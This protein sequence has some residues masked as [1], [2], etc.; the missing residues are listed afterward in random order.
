MPSRATENVRVTRHIH[1]AYAQ[2]LTELESVGFGLEEIIG[3]ASG[4]LWELAT[5]PPSTEKAADPYA[6]GW[7]A[8]AT[9]AAYHAKAGK[10]QVKNAWRYRHRSGDPS[11]LETRRDWIE[12]HLSNC[13]ERQAAREHLTTQEKSDQD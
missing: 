12:A 13:A 4:I 6:A 2:R 10:D 8:C 3:I 11:F 9:I 1:P 5:T 7:L